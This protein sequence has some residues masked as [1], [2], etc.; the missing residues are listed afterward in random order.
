MSLTFFFVFFE[1][2]L[3]ILFP[4]VIGFAIN[5]IVLKDYTGIY[6]L[7]ALGIILTISG[8]LRRMYDTRVYASIY[9]E[10]AYEVSVKQKENTTS[11]ISGKITMLKELVEFFENSFPQL[12][13]S[14]VGLIGTLII[15]FGLNTNIFIACLVMMIFICIIFALSSKRT[16]RYNHNYNNELEK[17][18][19]ILSNE[20]KRKIKPF[21]KRMM[22]WNIKLSDVESINFSVIWLGMTALI[23][24][25]VLDA[26]TSSLAYGSIYLILQEVLQCFL[27]I[28]KN[29]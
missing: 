27:C 29:I 4:L 20:N 21:F 12:V 2:V 16:S 23:V 26:T 8:T 15:L 17:Q 9:K 18:V 28:I 11:A 19:D 10:L 24:F 14:M 7:I 5:G 13:N 6:Q 1:S 25:S 22:Y 3:L